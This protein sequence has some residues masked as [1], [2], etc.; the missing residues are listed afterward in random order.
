MHERKALKFRPHL[1]TL[2]LKG[3]KRV[4]SRLFDEKDIQTGDELELL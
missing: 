1:A 4:A 2:I 3:D